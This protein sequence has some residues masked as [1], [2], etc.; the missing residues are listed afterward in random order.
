MVNG[1][2]QSASARKQ[3]CIMTHRNSQTSASSANALGKPFYMH[4]R[5]FL[6]FA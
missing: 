4:P 6:A 5:E 1:F 3:S 2:S